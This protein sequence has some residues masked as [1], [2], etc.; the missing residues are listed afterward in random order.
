LLLSALGLRL[1]GRLTFD[2]GDH[3]EIFEAGDAFYLGPGHPTGSEPGTEYIQ[4]SPAEELNVV[5]ETINRNA[6]ALM[7]DALVA[8]G[9]TNKQ[10]AG[11]LFVTDR[12]VEGHLS[13]IYAKLGL[14]S[15]AELAAH[16]ALRG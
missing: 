10:V 14:R 6:Q 4:F 9:L 12:T 15:R 13:R 7:G 1:Q 8:E 5:S 11:R 2:C 3:N 16:V